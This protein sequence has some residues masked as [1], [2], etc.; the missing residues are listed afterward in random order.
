[1]HRQFEEELAAI[2][3]T[4][5]SM[6]GLAERALD[7]VNRA[8]T[9]RDSALARRV[10]DGDEEVDRY[11]VEI[12]RLVSEFIVRHQP[13]AMDLRF[14]VVA[15]KLGPELER[16]GD[17][18]VNIARRVLDLNEQ[19]LLKP[20]IDLPRMLNLARAMVSD[21]IAAFVAR[22][23]AAARAVIERDDEVDQL[24]LQL[25]RELISYMIEDPRTITRAID[26][27]F[28]ARF[29]ER[30]ADQAT[31]ISEEVVYLVEGV[32]IRHQHPEAGGSGGED[33]A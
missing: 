27:I 32:P 20:L 30:I 28:V 7:D 14:V 23:P 18:A 25:L 4:V 15:I 12:D 22:D 19:P 6:A 2:K 16:I 29:A 1:M 33:P 8:L 17:H 3:A 21:A 26:L 13:A 11:E 31:N 9:G 10:I 5:L 24:Y